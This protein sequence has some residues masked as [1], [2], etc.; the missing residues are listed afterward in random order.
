M[1]PQI[2]FSRGLGLYSHIGLCHFEILCE[3]HNA[4]QT[5]QFKAKDVTIGQVFRPIADYLIHNAGLAL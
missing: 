3:K 1:W 2:V 4:M 5:R